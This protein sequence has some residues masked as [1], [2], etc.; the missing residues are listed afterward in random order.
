[1]EVA[2]AAEPLAAEPRVAAAEP[3]VIRVP[4]AE[5]PE[6]KTAAATT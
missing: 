1:M 5:I 3:L 2:M 4:A 6:V